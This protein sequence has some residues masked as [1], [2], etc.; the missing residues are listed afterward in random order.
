MGRRHENTKRKKVANK[1]KDKVTQVDEMTVDMGKLQHI[2]KKRKSGSAPGMDGIQNFWW[3][4]LI[5]TWRPLANALKSWIDRSELIPTWIT[6]GRTV[7]IP[8]SEELSDKKNY[9]PIT[10]L[11]PRY[12]LGYSASI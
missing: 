4:K 6:H 11:N 3:K 1:R 7:L 8:K 2:L 9:R 12:L 5:S 10:C